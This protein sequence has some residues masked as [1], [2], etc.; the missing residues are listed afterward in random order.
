MHNNTDSENV[1]ELLE[2]FRLERLE[3][4]LF[5]G[6]SRAMESKRVFGGMVLGQALTAASHTVEEREAHSL[7]AFFLRAGDPDM[8]IIYNVDRSRDGRSFT[9]R[10][11]VAI[12][13]GRPI[14]NMAASFQVPEEGLSHQSDMPQVP[15]P[16][17]LEPLHRTVDQ[18]E[19]LPEKVRRLFVHQRPFEF[20]PVVPIDLLNPTK[21]APQQCIWFRT[22]AP[23]PDDDHL[24]RC[25]LAYVSDYN[26]LPTASLPHGI[27]FLQGNVQMAS[28]DHAMWF[29]R[30]ARIDDWMLYSIDSPNASGARGFA[31]GSIFSRDGTLVASTAQE[32]VL[33]LWD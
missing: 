29:H 17:D 33:R 8:P 15:A 2:L 27:S 6:P 14:L 25:L 13:H 18:G 1:D 24:I 16:E 23:V 28:L 19:K 11:V 32:G 31:R 3:D 7:H 30:H 5:R 4:D 9:N 26:L 20:R 22:V 10:R 21:Q 12:Q